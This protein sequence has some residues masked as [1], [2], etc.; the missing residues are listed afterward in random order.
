MF[1]KAIY[2]VAGFIFS[3]LQFVVSP[4]SVIFRDIDPQ[5]KRDSSKGEEKQAEKS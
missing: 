3:V 4:A 2:K 1:K 5:D